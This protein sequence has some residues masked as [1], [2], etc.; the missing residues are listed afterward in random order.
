MTPLQHKALGF[1]GDHIR[2]FG[3]S[4]SYGEIAS[5]IGKARSQTHAV[6]NALVAQGHLV[7]SGRG[8]RNLS[9]VGQGLEHFSDAALAA[10]QLRRALTRGQQS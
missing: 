6:V 8:D 7:K 10:E 1:I 9:L 3:F 5:A 2:I 4:P